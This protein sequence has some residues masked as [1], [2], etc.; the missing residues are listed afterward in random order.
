[1]GRRAHVLRALRCAQE[2]LLVAAKE[3]PLQHRAELTRQFD[4]VTILLMGM[5]TATARNDLHL[6]D[7][8]HPRHAAALDIAHVYTVYDALL[9]TRK[10]LEEIL[11]GTAPEFAAGLLAIPLADHVQRPLRG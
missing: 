3:A 10:R 5:E 7:F 4:A 1:M 11:N 2:A 9:L 6:S 8:A